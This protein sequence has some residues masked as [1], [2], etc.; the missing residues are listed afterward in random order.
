MSLATQLFITD[1][2]NVFGLDQ[3]IL[4]LLFK[5]P[6]RKECGILNE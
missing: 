1:G 5:L 2:V 3:I 6:F 4:R